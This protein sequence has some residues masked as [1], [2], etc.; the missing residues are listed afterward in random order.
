MPS[1]I[2]ENRDDDKGAHHEGAQTAPGVR[3]L[4]Q[5]ELSKEPPPPEE[6]VDH[7]PL[8]T[9]QVHDD[10]HTIGAGLFVGEGRVAGETFGA[11]ILTVNS[12]VP[13]RPLPFA[14]PIR[15]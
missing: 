1:H 7:V 3:H 11:A 5:P 6:D 10:G 2:A 4:L 12:T 8:E 15:P 9:D 13:P 14:L